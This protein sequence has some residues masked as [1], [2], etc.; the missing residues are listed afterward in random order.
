MEWNGICMN[1]V[2]DRIMKGVVIA[3]LKIIHTLR[4]LGIMVT[5]VFL[6]IKLF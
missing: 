3:G 4:L 5:T 6:Y 1:A 2:E